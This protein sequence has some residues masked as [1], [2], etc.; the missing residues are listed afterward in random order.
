MSLTANT[1]ES[2]RDYLIGKG[3]ELSNKTQVRKDNFRIPCPACGKFDA[4]D[5]NIRTGQWKCLRGSCQ[6]GGGFYKLKTL[7]GDAYEIDAPVAKDRAAFNA[8]RF[9]AELVAA[10]RSTTAP[11]VEEVVE[12]ALDPV[13]RWHR[14]L[15][16]SAAAAPAREYLEKRGIS[17]RVI[18]LAKLGWA[19]SPPSNTTD[20]GPASPARSNAP[21]MVRKTPAAAR[22][23]ATSS[24]SSSGAERVK[25]PP[26]GA[27][28]AQK[29][30][31]VPPAPSGPG[32]NGLITIPYF[33]EGKVVLV[34]L[35]WVPPEPVDSKTG[36]VRR[37]QRIAGG[38]TVLYQPFGAVDP[39][40]ELLLVGG[41]LDALSAGVALLEVGES[42]TLNVA[43][44]S[45][46]E[47][48]WSDEFGEVLDPCEDIV[49]I[50]DSDAAGR[51]GAKKVAEAMGKHRVRIGSWPE[52]HKD[53]NDALRA[54]DLEG[55]T[56][57]GILKAAKSPVAASVST[58]GDKGGEYLARRAGGALAKSW[59]TG[60]V[61]VDN[62]TGGFRPGEATVWTGETGIGKTTVVLEMV[63]NGARAGVR[64][65]L[66]PFEDGAFAYLDK[67]LRRETGRRPETIPDEEVLR[68]LR[69]RDNLWILDHQGEVKPDAL[70]ATMLYAMHRLGVRAFLFDHI[71]FMAKRG[72]SE[73]EAKDVLIHTIQSTIRDSPAHAHVL[74]HPSKASSNEAKG[75][76]DNRVI[77]LSDVKGH[78]TV[79]QDFANVASVWRP[80][81]ADRSEIT[82]KDTDETDHT[83]VLVWLKAR[84]ANGREGKVKLLF[85]PATERY[86]R[87]PWH[88]TNPIAFNP[89]NPTATD[90]DRERHQRVEEDSPL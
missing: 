14:D 43:A 80:R 59:T 66:C 87:H 27:A 84:H 65:L 28:A 48:G 8:E 6:E 17:R 19:S 47:G 50:Y 81:R 90:E 15:L 63:D 30:A 57:L 1:D 60:H 18:E 29:S 85:D 64:S 53:A 46:G 12:A 25:R 70:R 23:F 26:K 38:R 56:M 13:E 42:G 76:K 16:E 78:S 54:G 41:E 3:F 45:A 35:R 31:Q 67:I 5:V 89:A 71:D 32:S 79:T 73:S 69:L 58:V 49:V 33:D 40:R 21:P 22:R 88:F 74:A 72:R 52:P 24:E 44:T 77:Q 75:A 20:A 61:D 36:K 9:E 86:K 82:V 62:L 83:V 34:K 7:F 68:I 37:Y 10:Y 55:F 51:A 4:C 39:E 11:E 2:P